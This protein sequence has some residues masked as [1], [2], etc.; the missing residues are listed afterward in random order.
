LVTHAVSREPL[1]LHRT[2]IAAN[3]TKADVDPPRLLLGGH[4]KRNGVIRLWPDE[5]ITYGLLV[6]EGIETSLAAAHDYT[7]AWACIDANNTAA[8]PVL[9]GIETLVIAADHDAAGIRA[10]TECANRWTAAGVE[11]H[12]LTPT[13]AK[14]DWADARAAA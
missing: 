3:G 4:T 10:A 1:T 7:P 11:V 6:A 14:T 8:M 13:P 9:D 5:C 2:W 12:V